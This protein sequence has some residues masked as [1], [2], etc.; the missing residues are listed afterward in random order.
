M[1][2]LV[3]TQELKPGLVIFRR[4]D[5]KHRN[6]YCR[7]KLPQEDR[8]KTVSLKTAD[9]DAAREKAFDQD[10]DVRFRIKHDVPIFNR[11]FSQIAKDYIELQK[12]RVEAGQIAPHRVRVVESVVRAQLN[13]YMGS[14]QI[15][16]IGRD[17][18]LNF[19]LWRQKTWRE[20]VEREK[21]DR[22]KNEQQTEPQRE[23]GAKNLRPRKEHKE[24]PARVSDASVRS[25]MEVFRSIMAYAASKKYIPDIQML[26]GKLPLD[27]VRREEFTPEEYRKLHTF[28]RGWVKK[29]R[30]PVQTWYRTIAYNFVLIMCNTGM[31]PTEAKNLRWRDVA[32]RGDGQGRNFV[33]LHVR[34]KD[35]FRQLV[36]ASNVVDYLERIRAIAKATEPDGFVFT[37]AQGKR[38][39]LLYRSLIEGLLT[40]SG[41]RLSSSGSRRSTYCFRHTYATFRLTEGVDVYFLSKQMGT[42]VKMIEEHYGHINPVKNAERILQGLPGWEPISAAPQVV[43]ETGRVNADATKTRTTK[44]KAKATPLPH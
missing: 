8:Y 26:K 29:A 23:Q 34:G 35:K 40:E 30:T 22:K 9:I 43:P 44:P 11:P 21:E 32:I 15:N 36:A 16:L 38:A 2:F 24:R 12:L 28:A 14:I 17:R 37:T 18:W 7:I 20:K 41:L 3:D 25:E 1:A 19:P 6:W 5:V 33:V 13:P 42:S 27:K 4:A 31:R 10:A 39:A